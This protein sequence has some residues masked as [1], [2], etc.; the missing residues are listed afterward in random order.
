MSKA[1]RLL[2]TSAYGGVEYGNQLVDP[3][4]TIVAASPEQTAR[5]RRYVAGMATDA[6]DAKVLLAMLGL[7]TS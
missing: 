7:E 2:S 1:T 6:E 4:G 5:A 3:W